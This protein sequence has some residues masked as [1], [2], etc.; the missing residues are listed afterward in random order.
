MKMLGAMYK[1]EKEGVEV[2][3]LDAP[4][5]SGPNDVVVRMR[6]CG[7]CGTDLAILEGRHPAK[8]PVILGHECAGEV[9]QI[10][11]N[12]SS[13]Q[14]GDH[15]VIDPNLR[16][17]VCRY[18]RSDRP[19][20]CENLVSIGEDINGG[21]A[22]FTLAPEKA[23]YK[24]PKQ[25]DWV[26]AALAEPFSC[27]VNGFLRARVKPA[28]TAVVYGAGPMGLF[29]V[30]LFSRAGARKIMSVE[31]AS[32]RREAAKKV[33]AH[34]TIDPS[35]ED[36]VNRVRE[37]TDGLGAD[38]AVEVIGKIE[39]VEGAIRSSANGGRI[40]IMGT[41]R[42]DATAKFSPFDLMRYEK[43]ILGSHT[44]AATFRTAIEMLDAGFVPVNTI[45]THK[46][47]L[48]EISRAFSLNKAG[49]SVKTVVMMD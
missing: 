15:V 34:V 37:E 31:I 16:C 17:G 38:V 12:V 11:K 8:P 41:C 23:L 39:T 27:I 21:Y 10:G 3:E 9:A 33:G 28:D 18:C 4:E 47:P 44:Q 7:M 22:T 32:K 13:L 25:M 42:P 19:N 5:V 20:L 36:P 49:E 43:D 30:S 40:V 29:W 24:I 14:V 48:K 6:T 45:V 46:V 26:T 1:G 35:H 2:V